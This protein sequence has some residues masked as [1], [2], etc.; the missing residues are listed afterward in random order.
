[1]TA[2]EFLTGGTRQIEEPPNLKELRGP[3]F[4]LQLVN[5]IEQ[6]IR[7]IAHDRWT[8]NPST[9]EFNEDIKLPIKH[10]QKWAQSIDEQVIKAAG[11]AHPTNRESLE[12]MVSQMIQEGTIPDSLPLIDTEAMQPRPS[13]LPWH[14]FPPQQWYLV[15]ALFDI[16]TS[17][18]AT[19]EWNK[20]N[21]H[22]TLSYPYLKSIYPR[23]NIG[24]GSWPESVSITD[25]HE[26]MFQLIDQATQQKGGLKDITPP[27]D[28]IQ[29]LLRGDGKVHTAP[30][31]IDGVYA[32]VTTDSF[33]VADKGEFSCK[34]HPNITALALKLNSSFLA[35]VRPLTQE[36]YRQYV[37]EED[38]KRWERYRQEFEEKYGQK[39]EGDKEAEEPR[40]PSRPETYDLKDPKGYYKTLGV[41]PNTDPEDLDDVLQSAYRRLSQKYHP[42]A[43]GD[44]ADQQKMVEINLAYEFLSKPENRK[45]YVG[46]SAEDWIFRHKSD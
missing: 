15:R 10:L 26:I 11:D 4:T 2:P 42:D 13:I 24:V 30:T 29:T 46:I 9:Q 40:K 27:K 7:D 44:T 25:V 33:G 16:D 41:N 39:K 32:I 8:G 1:M 23:S 19:M 31:V 18:F 45:N 3:N 20:P 5:F 34:G 12:Q 35:S 6:Y 36:E 38:E 17:G 43:G 28:A 14:A 22:I 37:S 21:L